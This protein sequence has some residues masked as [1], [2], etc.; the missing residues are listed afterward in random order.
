M[1]Q[2]IVLEGGINQITGIFSF[3]SG[4]GVLYKYLCCDSSAAA[5]ALEQQF[6]PAVKGGSSRGGSPWDKTAI[7]AKE[8]LL[9]YTVLPQQPWGK[10]S[11]CIPAPDGATGACVVSMSGGKSNSCSEE[12]QNLTHQ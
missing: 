4:L 6:S 2:S 7:A 5:A 9:T 8:A 12:K 10:K 1:P 3:H 11:R